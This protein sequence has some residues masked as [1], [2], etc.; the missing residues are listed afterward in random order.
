MSNSLDLDQAQHTV[1][2]DL[3]PNCLQKL[4]A[5]NTSRQ[6]IKL[7]LHVTSLVKILAHEL[8]YTTDLLQLDSL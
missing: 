5:D 4:S 8:K 6:R 7:P 2:P 1:E 3:V